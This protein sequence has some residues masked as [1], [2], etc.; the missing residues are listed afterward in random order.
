MNF[1]ET[2]VGALVLL[3]LHSRMSKLHHSHI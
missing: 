3:L 2:K 1:H